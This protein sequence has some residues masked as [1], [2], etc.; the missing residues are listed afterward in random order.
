M[1]ATV[2]TKKLVAAFR[3]PAGEPRY[4]LF[5]ET[6]S[7]NVH[8]RTPHWDALVIG[9]LESVLQTIFTAAA[10]CEGGMLQGACGRP[11][12]PESYIAAW[13][14]ELANP[15][16]MED[17]MIELQVSDRYWASIPAGT[18]PTIRN[19]LQELGEHNIL[20]ALDA[21]ESVVVSLHQNSELL[22]AIYGGRSLGAWRVIPACDLRV[23]GVRDPEL[24]Y[25]PKKS[26]ATAPAAPRY[27]KVGKDDSNLLA[28]DIDGTW[29]CKGWAHSIV[30]ELVKD[31]WQ[32]ELEEP[33]WYRARVRA[34][35]EAV[36]AAECMPTHGVK[37]VVDKALAAHKYQ[38]E[39]IEA[40]RLKFPH[41]LMGD[42]VH[43][44]VPA[45]EADLYLIT[46]LPTECTRW[47]IGGGQPNLLAVP[48]PATAP[49]HQLSLLA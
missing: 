46:R 23:H 35:R 32:S 36:N 2:S 26:K 39:Y 45:G 9:G 25:T 6:Y 3:N 15:V 5:E 49:F 48:A 38:Q 4:V 19:S 1:G 27:L 40:A 37:V 44:Q 21:G 11:I 20:A 42:E 31:L 47:I 28:Q 17:R 43:L 13:L 22:G 24:G 41:E 10:A 18:F 12:T 33:G 16:L 34:L 14:K 7:K 8:P 29:T 30:A